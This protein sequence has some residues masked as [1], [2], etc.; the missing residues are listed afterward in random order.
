MWASSASSY[1]SRAEQTSFH[2]S[3]QPS[4]L[5]LN[6]KA[7]FNHTVINEMGVQKC[8]EHAEKMKPKAEEHFPFS[9]QPI[10]V[11]YNFMQSSYE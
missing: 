8:C 4:D 9:A 7:P 10:A 6:E 5:N 11:K 3:H 1:I 2:A